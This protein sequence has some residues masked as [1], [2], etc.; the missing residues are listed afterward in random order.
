MD[1][2]SFSIQGLSDVLASL[3]SETTVVQLPVEEYGL[4]LEVPP[5]FS[6]NASMVLHVLKGDPTLQD[7]GHVQVGSPGMAYLFFYDKQGH[8]GLKQ[9]VAVNLQ[10]HMAEVFSE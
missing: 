9:D 8:K 3:N 7:L 6:W 5:T 10:M 4:L 2:H 1:M